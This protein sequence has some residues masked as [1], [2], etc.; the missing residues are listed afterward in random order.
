MRNGG[1]LDR[2]SARDRLRADLGE[3]SLGGEQE[4]E[5]DELRRGGRQQK[6]LRRAEQ[7]EQRDGEKAAEKKANRES[8]H[9]A[10]ELLLHL[11]HVEEPSA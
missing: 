11:S 5:E 7:S 6:L 4:P 10:W 8:G 3:S 9:D 1:S 2:W